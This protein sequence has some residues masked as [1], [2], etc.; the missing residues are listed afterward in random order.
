MH[1]ISQLCSVSTKTHSKAQQSTTA[2]SLAGHPLLST[3]TSLLSTSSNKVPDPAVSDDPTSSEEEYQA[4]CNIL[5]QRN[6]LDDGTDIDGSCD[7]SNHFAFAA[8]TQNN[9]DVLSRLRR[10]KADDQDEFLKTEHSKISGLHDAGIFEY[11]PASNIPSDR[12]HKLLNSIW[13]YRC[14]R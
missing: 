14:K 2:L 11:M 7:I 3:L 10:L 9:P 4:V 13:S 8:G 12:R 1:I 6:I 5:D